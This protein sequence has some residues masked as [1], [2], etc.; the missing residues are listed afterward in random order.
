MATITGLTAD[1]MQ[2][3][4]DAT[5]VDADVISGSLILTKDDG[6][7]INAG[8]VVGPTGATGATGATGPTGPG[9][10]SGGVAKVS[11]FPV[12]PAPT[13]GDLVI[14]I[15]QPAD[16]LYKFSDGVWQRQP[17]Q[18]PVG[19]LI[20]ITGWVNTRFVSGLAGGTAIVKG[21]GLFAASGIGGGGI[22]DV[23]GVTGIF[24][25]DTSRYPTLI[26]NLYI[27]TIHM[28]NSVAPAIPYS[29][30]LYQFSAAGGGSDSVT[31]T[32]GTLVGTYNTVQGAVNTFTRL[33]SAAIPMPAAG[34][35]VL[36]GY[37]GGGSNA[38]EA[39][40]VISRILV[41]E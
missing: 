14:R 21:D 35:Y 26:Q 5:I 29:A 1:R 38:G 3:I 36:A 16:P 25:L 13:D 30:R 10:S 2:E 39:R 34:T 19:L 23:G 6:S 33:R 37:K 28:Q 4:I 40:A 31:A 15:D 18:L 9:G 27:E 12:S 7:T 8:N 20:P 41:G 32:L 17:H 11:A 24:D 22:F